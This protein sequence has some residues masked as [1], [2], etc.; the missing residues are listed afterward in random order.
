[1][2]VISRDLDP[3]LESRLEKLE[4]DTARYHLQRLGNIAERH[5]EELTGLTQATI[6]ENR[7]LY[8]EI[9]N[10]LEVARDRSKAKLSSNNLASMRECIEGLEDLNRINENDI[11]N[12]CRLDEPRKLPIRLQTEH[13]ILTDILSEL[14]DLHDIRASDEVKHLQTFIEK[15]LEEIEKKYLQLMNRQGDDELTP[16]ERLELKRFA[17]T[18]SAM[19]AKEIT[20]KVQWLKTLVEQRESLPYV[21]SVL[22]K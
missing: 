10:S 2:T 8:V 12:L 5:W 11:V 6:D 7:D 15:R 19:R 13:S 18:T 14:K 4:K 20:E 9:E 1:M 22:K 16:E 21:Q 3:T 17:K